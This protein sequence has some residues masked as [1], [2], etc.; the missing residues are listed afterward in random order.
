MLEKDK[1]ENQEFSTENNLSSIKPMA[2]A[3]VGTTED[4]WEEFEIDPP[5]IKDV[6]EAKNEDAEVDTFNWDT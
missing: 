2:R 4:D 1:N 5:F 3:E 6:K